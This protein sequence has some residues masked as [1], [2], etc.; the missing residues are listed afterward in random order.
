M[1]VITAAEVHVEDVPA[2]ESPCG[3]TRLLRYSDHGRLTQF[4]AFVEILPP[5]SR[6]SLCHWHLRED[7]MVLMLEG[8]ATLIEGGVATTL[9]AGDAACFPA[10]APLGHFLRNDGTVPA[11]YVVVGT[12]SGADVITYPDHDRVTTYDDR[13][14]TESFATLDG[15]PAEGSAYALPGA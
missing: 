11:R 7:E 14:G 12:R 13:A 2:G 1:P 10:G 15:R 6:S 4:G 5:G 9:R 8:E 3:P